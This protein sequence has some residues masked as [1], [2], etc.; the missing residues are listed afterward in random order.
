MAFVKADRVQETSVTTG[1]G[2]F[3]LAGAYN[4]SFKTFDDVMADGDTCQALIL[5]ED[6]PGEWVVA[7]CTYSADTLT[8]NTVLSNSLNTT[9]PVTF[10]SGDKRIA[11]LAPASQSVVEDNS[12]NASVSNNLTVTGSVTVGND[13]LVTDDLS[14]GG[15]LTITGAI[16]FDDVTLDN[17]IFNGSTSG[18]TTVRASAT[19]SGTLTLPAAT[20]TLVGKATTDTLTNKTF[21][22]AGTGNS[23]SIAGVAVTANT[24]TGAV[25]RAVSPSFT[26][27][28]LGT[29]SAAVLTNATGLPL[30]TGVTGNLPVSNLNSGTSA[31]ATTFWRGDGSWATPAAGAVS[32]GVGSTAVTGGATTRVLY[33]NAGTLGE[34]VIS[35][36]GN[37]AMTTSPAFTTPDL[38]TPS[39]A[40]LT[41]A[42][43]LP[44]ST[45][46]SGLGAGIA[47]WLGTPSSANLAT[48]V[49]DETGTGSLV[50]A[51]SPALT[52]T[53]TA[54][55][56][57]ASTNTTQ[58]AT[59]AFS[60][61]ATAYNNP[62]MIY[63]L[64]LST[65][66]SS[67]TLSFAVGR[68]TDSTGA[69][70]MVGTALAKTTSAWAA[71]NANGMLDTGAIANSTQYHMFLI[72]KTDGTTDYLCSTSPSAPTLPATYVYF[73]RIGSIKTNGSSQWQTF[74]QVED[75]FY[76][77]G[78]SDY[79]SV[80]ATSAA[81][82]RTLSVPT[83]VVVGATGYCTASASPAAGGAQIT[84]SPAGQ[85]NNTQLVAYADGSASSVYGAGL[86]YNVHTNTSAQIYVSVPANAGSV[87]LTTTGWIDTRGK[88]Y[89]P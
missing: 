45:G 31:S 60:I 18:T 41:N 7:E 86:F 42:T 61:A 80:G 8:V 37:V 23:L 16:T 69:V 74:F 2:P 73:R 56:A 79:T 33:D 36:T 63:G 88:E 19:A 26:T 14:V 4:A 25:A 10:T 54:P 34:Y 68:A 51:G 84:V 29:P 55:T 78:V 13:L 47:T 65:A 83:G 35:G 21:D 5:N 76:I 6:A 77:P 22:T 82:L 15:D 67:T 27:P 49:T 57:S 11:M 24:G 43:G 40:T 52:G 38:G 58:I 46:V 70:V 62:G 59:T 48:A 85:S 53:P 81:T 32:I 20:D 89:L 9:N 72:A 12:G 28:A 64:T 71:G 30:S 87:S 39:A 50:F 66:G 1:T 17:V 75:R 3:T 44:I